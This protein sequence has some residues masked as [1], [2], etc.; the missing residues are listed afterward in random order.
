MLTGVSNG[1]D[2]AGFQQLLPE[3]AQNLFLAVSSLGFCATCW[4]PVASAAVELGPFQ[5]GL[6]ARAAASVAGLWLERTEQR[7]PSLL[8]P[9]GLALG[10]T[11]WV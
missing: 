3:Q 8:R 2:A 1:I 6:Q 10:N 9:A 7:G 4:R 5:A 11:S